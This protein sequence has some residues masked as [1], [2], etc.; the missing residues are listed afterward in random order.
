MFKYYGLDWLGMGL[1]LL[2]VY[3]L[4]N[5]NKFGF[6]SFIGSNA[7]FVY[8]GATLMNSWGVAI[9]NAIFLIMNIRGFIRWFK[10]D[11]NS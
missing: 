11:G 4:G 3:L 1:A 10:K 9:G 7:I 6:I 8:L 2:A 5:R